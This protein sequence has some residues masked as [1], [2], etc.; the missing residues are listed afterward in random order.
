MIADHSGS[1]CVYLKAFRIIGNRG[2]EVICA[3][4][5]LHARVVE[6]DIHLRT[7]TIYLVKHSLHAVQIGKLCLD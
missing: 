5:Y 7:H 6:Y 1:Y 3:V 4:R 2:L